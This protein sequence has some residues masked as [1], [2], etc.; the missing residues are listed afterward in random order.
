MHDCRYCEASFEDEDAYLEHLAGDHDGE[1]GPIERRKIGAEDDDSGG[2]PTGPLALVGVLLVAVAIVAYVLTAGG[3]GGG[4]ALADL[5]D[6]GDDA[7]I[8]Q[9]Q[10]EPND[11]TT[12]VD[13]GEAEYDRIPPT[14]GAHYDPSVGPGFYTEE[15]TLGELVHSLEHGY[16]VVW[17]DPSALSSDAEENLRTYSNEYTGR[18]KGFIAV[19]NPSDDPEAN[20]VLTTWGKR[21]TMDQYDEDTVRA[22]TAEYIGRGPEN[23]VR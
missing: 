2:L 14:G 21:L 1:L 10:D 19:P 17:Y 12:H 9:V 20:Y 13:R 3:G 4:D 11:N 8:S 7:V 16:I 6:R 23:P 22:F 15:Q 18:F 5:P